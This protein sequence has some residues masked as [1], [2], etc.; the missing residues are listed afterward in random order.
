MSKYEYNN[1]INT[2]RNIIQAYLKLDTGESPCFNVT[3]IVKSLKINRGT[4]YLHFNSLDA[5]KQCIEDSLAV[6]FK[7]IE[8]D[9][10]LSEIDKSPEIII[11]K[12]N[13]IL[14]KD[15]E[16]YNLLLNSNMHSKL[17]S[18]VKISLLNSIS[19]NFQVMKYVMN[20]EHFK[21]VV[22]FIVGGL[23]T[24]YK[25]W[26]KGRLD[27]TLDDISVMLGKMIRL[28]LKGCISY[29]N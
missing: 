2:R 23:I 25:E 14:L 7:P 15:I 1:S 6:D 29:G 13:E 16:Y 4:F 5:V 24:T 20:Y 11:N 8:Q 19:N 26:F 17:S 21:M 18:R 10:R 9:F 22:E 3:D 28:G 27:T 12:L